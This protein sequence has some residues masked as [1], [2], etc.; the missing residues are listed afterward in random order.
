M[1]NRAK[2]VNKPAEHHKFK[3]NNK[4]TGKTHEMGSKLT[5]SHV[6]F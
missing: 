4:D 2:M 3:V 6:R 5:K 1:E